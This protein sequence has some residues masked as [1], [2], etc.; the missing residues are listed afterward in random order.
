M[1]ENCF[2]NQRAVTVEVHTQ[3]RNDLNNREMKKAIRNQPLIHGTLIISAMDVMI[4]NQ[5]CDSDMDR[6]IISL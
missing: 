1:R 3:L 5:I 4:G 6:R 2:L